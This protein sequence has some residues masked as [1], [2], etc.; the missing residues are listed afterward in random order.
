MGDWLSNTVHLHSEFE[1]PMRYYYWS[2]L[3][4][5]S[6]ALKDRVFLDRFSYKLYPN[7]YVILFGP[8][9]VKKGP[10]ISLAK[11]VVT[12]LE[13]TRVINGRSSVESIMK[14]LGTSKKIGGKTITDSCA[15]I[16]SSEMSSAVISSAQS[17]DIMT[18]LGDRIYNTGEWD[19][20][21]KNSEPIKLKAPTITWLSGT[22]EALFR[23]FVPEKNLKGGLIGRTFII[24]EHKENRINSLMFAPE[25]IPDRAKIAQSIEHLR[26]LKGEMTMEKDVRDAFDDWYI[27]FKTKIIPKLSDDTGTAERACDNIL[28]IAMIISCAKRADLIITI[29]DIEEAMKEV[30]SLLAPTKKVSNNAK[31]NIISMGEKTGMILKYLANNDGHR[32]NKVILLRKFITRMDHEDL[33]KI[34]HGLEQSGVLRTN[35]NGNNIEY[36]L[37]MDKKEVREYVEG[38]QK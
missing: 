6:A 29:D 12:R 3:S 5:V 1:P 25:V 14:D 27:N 26:E 16:S 28:K 23:E 2:C 9:G 36:E 38:Y 32:E 7:I 10:P 34:I 19:Y 20:R 30:I 8:S 17:L 33:D 31:Q 22:N 4:I 24:S 13:I 15:F 35:R 11:D 21:L 18:D 37:R